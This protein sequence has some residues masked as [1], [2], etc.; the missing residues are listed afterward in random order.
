MTCPK[1]LLY[2]TKPYCTFP[3]SALTATRTANHNIYTTRAV[4]KT[5]RL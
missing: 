5:D 3:L 2:L 1:H 4:S